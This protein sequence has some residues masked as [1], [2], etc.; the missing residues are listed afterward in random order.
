MC[1]AHSVSF[2]FILL[3]FDLT[4]LSSSHVNNGKCSDNTH[5]KICRI[6]DDWEN[7]ME[8]RSVAA[9]QVVSCLFILG[10]C[11]VIQ[12][13]QAFN[14]KRSVLTFDCGVLGF[15]ISEKTL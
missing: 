1:R 14:S 7:L 15:L 5:G 9:V 4:L 6:S 13:S 11:M 8:W 12:H 3:I 10:K 2:T